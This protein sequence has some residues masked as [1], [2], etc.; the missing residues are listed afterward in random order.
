[1]IALI[2]RR[3]HSNKLWSV[4]HLNKLNKRP[5]PA[6]S[7]SLIEQAIV[8]LKIMRPKKQLTDEE[9][10][11][12]FFLEKE[13]FAVPIHEISVLAY[14]TKFFISPI[15]FF[16]RGLKEYIEQPFLP[17]RSS[18]WNVVLNNSASL[19][20]NRGFW[21]QWNAL[22]LFILTNFTFVLNWISK[23]AGAHIS[24][25]EIFSSNSITD[26]TN[27]TEKRLALTWIPESITRPPLS[28]CFFEI[29]SPR[30]LIVLHLTLT[31]AYDRINLYT[32]MSSELLLKRLET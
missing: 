6:G 32:L 3:G 27:F 26:I 29:I 19:N 13:S 15:F 10:D 20:S 11:H 30:Y 7:A 5:T 16:L 12:V 21:T 24:T 17:M 18:K 14:Y 2:I 8:L 23:E 9:N 28:S 4:S 25:K 22:P 31:V 1:M